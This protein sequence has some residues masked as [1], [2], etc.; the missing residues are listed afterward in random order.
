MRPYQIYSDK[1]LLQL[2]KEDNGAAFK[3]LYDR[4]YQKLLVLAFLKINNQDDA[5]EIVQI[6]FVNLWRRR[7]AV[8]IKYSFHTYIASVLKYEIL[9]YF[10][11][12]RKE[13]IVRDAVLNEFDLKD[14]ST[15]NFL[16]Y[17]QL[18]NDIEKTICLLPEKCRLV[19]RLSRQEGMTEKEICEAL[20]IAPKTAQAHLSKALKV[21]RSSLNQFF[22]AFF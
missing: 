4:Y 22:L 1:E 20:H 19:F 6:V 15:T 18:R 3:E 8:K 16:A 11:K 7:G 21:L 17:D 2:V 9:S 10:A 14:Y 5:E 13:G 12:K